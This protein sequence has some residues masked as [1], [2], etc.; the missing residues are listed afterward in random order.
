VLALA[1]RAR[2]RVHECACHRAVLNRHAH[3][4][5]RRACDQRRPSQHRN[6]TRCQR[7]VSL[8]CRTHSTSDLGSS[9]S[10][11]LDLRTVSDGYC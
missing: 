1:G 5:T 3:H 7:D 4:S 2:R 8:L 6:D 11:Q 9:K 10:A